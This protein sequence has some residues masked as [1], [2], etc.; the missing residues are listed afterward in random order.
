VNLNG[1]VDVIGTGDER[2]QPGAEAVDTAFMLGFQK[3]DP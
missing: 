3:S 1:S 2:A